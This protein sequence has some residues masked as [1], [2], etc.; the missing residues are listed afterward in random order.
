[1][2]RRPR[3]FGFDSVR[4]TGA[5]V[6]F[7]LTRRDVLVGVGLASL[8]VLARIRFSD[9]RVP[10]GEISVFLAM[11]LLV[12]RH[13]AVRTTLASLDP[14]RRALVV[15]LPALLVAGHV[16]NLGDRPYPFVSWELYAT[17]LPSNPAYHEYTATLASGRVVPLP[18]RDLFPTLAGRMAVF[19][20]GA[21]WRALHAGSGPSQALAAAHVDAL[22]RALA[23]EH[24]RRH[25]L[26]PIRAVD[27]WHRTIPTAR[28]QGRDSIARR[29]DWRADMP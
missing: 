11:G 29:H 19:L 9:H 1:M 21:A 23:R 7:H 4:Y 25:G 13:A 15:L 20:D 14:G 27:V 24:E 5:G 10:I 3:G 2:T 17:S 28:Y 8:A 6:G 22:L 16:A 26:G 12:S 18:V